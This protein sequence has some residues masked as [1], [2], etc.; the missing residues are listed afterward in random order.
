MKRFIGVALLCAMTVSLISGC[1][2]ATVETTESTEVSES[3][4]VRPQDDYYWYVNETSLSNA[5]FEY[6]EH[7]VGDAADTSLVDSQLDTVIDEVIAGSGYEAG[8][9]EF[10]IQTAYKSFLDYDFSSEPIPEEL[11][12]LIDEVNNAKTVDEL[13]VLDAKAYRDFQVKSYF[14][15]NVANNIFASDGKMIAFYP[16]SGVGSGSF[17][18]M[19]EDNFAL[20]S[21]VYDVKT[22][23]MTL[24]YD[25][26]TSEEYGRELAYLTLEL[27]SNTDMDIQDAADFFGYAEH[28]SADAIDGLFT[29]VDVEKLLAEIGFNT[30]YC[31]DFCILDQG[32]IECLNSIMVDENVDALKA[33]K[34]LSI[35]SRYMRFIAPHYEGLADYVEDSYEEPEKQ[36][37]NEI[38]STFSSETDV[39][40]VERFYTK[41]TDD[42]LLKMCGDIKEGYRDVITN[43]TWLT[44]TTRMNLL[45]KLDNIVFV[46]GSDIKRHD[47]SK[48]SGLTGDYFDVLIK[49][50]K[51]HITDIISSMEKPVDRKDVTSLM[52]EVNAFYDPTVNNVTICTAITNA[53]YFDSKADYFTNLGGLG[54]VIG[55]E[56]G[57]AFDS[58]GI[59]F[60]KNGTYN[61]NLIPDEDRQALKERD[62]K[63]ITYFEDNFTVFGVYHVD[64]E[65]TLAENYADLGGMEVIVSLA[66]TDEDLEKLFVNYAVCW[67][68]KKTDK[69]II[70][71]LAYDCHSPEVIRVNAILGTVDCFYDVYDVKEGDGMYISPENRISR[72]Y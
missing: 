67:C 53:P 49:Y 55:H 44:E 61:P 2:P 5:V 6:G 19:R 9:E 42:A 32:Q 60:D 56:I 8:S 59:Y 7:Y 47:N 52:Q 26:E 69:A 68:L 22:C 15:I 12:A 33:W 57:H 70:N 11:A 29:N 51:I 27:Y 18:D 50:Q 38:L 17:N 71:Q 41:D 25:A 4:P 54:S 40:Y 10:V 13:L 66:K 58:S 20:N 39:I 37:K 31:N 14:S 30:D 46:T 64:G 62:Q 63:A 23:M 65:K 28:Y 16:L 24:G 3:A 34:I 72:W 21:L 35:Y 43:A 36:A 1:S 48:Y 45:A